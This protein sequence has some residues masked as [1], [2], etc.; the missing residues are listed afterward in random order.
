MSNRKNYRY[1][2]I[3]TF[4]L[5][6]NRAAVDQDNAR[7]FVQSVY[8]RKSLSK[9]TIDELYRV[10]SEFIKTTGADV[11]MPKRPKKKFTPRSNNRLEWASPA[12]IEL[13]ENY[14]DALNLEDF[15]LEALRLRAGGEK[16]E[17]PTKKQAQN[18]IEAMKEMLKRDWK[19]KIAKKESHEDVTWH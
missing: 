19:P 5:V 9:L 7:A 16:F 6:A 14:A 1:K 2:L 12:Q 10:V 8:P 4:W 13:I 18:M 17:R 15:H 3:S 11:H